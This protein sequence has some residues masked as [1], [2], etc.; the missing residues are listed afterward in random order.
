MEYWQK[1]LKPL[2]CYNNDGPVVPKYYYVPKEKLDAERRKP[3]SQIRLPSNDGT[4]D[5][6]FLWGQAVLLISQLLGEFLPGTGYVRFKDHEVFDKSIF[7]TRV[8]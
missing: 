2:L 8:L 1:A 7:Q 4:K 5:D 6:L 3:G